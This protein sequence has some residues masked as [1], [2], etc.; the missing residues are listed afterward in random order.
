MAGS[1][2]A[3]FAVPASFDQPPGPSDLIGA[4][5]HH[6]GLPAVFDGEVAKKLS[7]AAGGGGVGFPALK[8]G[9]V[10]HVLGPD[11]VAGAS[12]PDLLRIDEPRGEHDVERHP[13][14][15]EVQGELN[16]RA[17]APEHV[18]DVGGPGVILLGM[19]K[20]TL[21]EH[22][23][24]EEQRGEAPEHDATTVRHA[25]QGAMLPQRT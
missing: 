2:D 20:P 3:K 16:P 22:P 5:H 1:G 24:Y 12:N 18:D 14:A 19:D 13:L 15:D 8:D 7:F 25:A 21:R 17:T 9:L 10:R 6:D 23:G 4:R 11:I